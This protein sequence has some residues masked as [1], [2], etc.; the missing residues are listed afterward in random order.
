MSKESTENRDVSQKLPRGYLPIWSISQ[1]PIAVG[2]LLLMQ[3]TF[4]ATEVVGLNPALIGAILMGTKF[5][6]AATDLFAGYIVDRT[7]TRW[8]RGRPM[9][10]FVV[11]LWISVI[12]LYSTPNFSTIG[13]AVWVGVMYSMAMSVCY[14]VLMASG[15]VYLKR[16]LSGSQRQGKVL[17]GTGVVIM[18]MSAV[19]SIMLPQLMKRWGSLPGGWTRIVLVYG[20]PMIVLGSIRFFL[21]KENVD[22]IEEDKQNKIGLIEGLKLVCGNKYVMIMAI[23]AVI[24]NVAK[25]ISAIAAA[26]YFTYVIG[27]IGTMSLVSAFGIVA[28]LTLLLFPLAMRKIGGMNFVRI[29]VA[30]AVVC[31]TALF[32]AGSNLPAVIASSVIGGIGINCLAMIGAVFT[33]QATDYGEWKTGKRIEGTAFAFNSFASKLGNG[34]AS[35]I[36]GGVMM[37]GGYIAKAP[38]QTP[39]ALLSIRVTYALIP[40]LCCIGVIIVL[41]A[42]DLEKKLPQITK[43]L[44]ARKAHSAAAE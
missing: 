14:T 30:V 13:K 5:F 21:I 42:F 36:A 32:F 29:N 37:L 6:D 8:G 25:N 24:D 17:A 35:L 7:N 27:D 23:V 20:L 28:P 9:H 18:V 16:S 38:E 34:L 39:R 43:D 22:T 1:A 12:L 40:A 4:Y 11:P 10:L 3:I 41:R 44:E 33:I 19:C 2:M 31:Y 15:G 26:Y